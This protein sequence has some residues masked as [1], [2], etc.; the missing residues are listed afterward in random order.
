MH[1]RAGS[2]MILPLTCD[3]FAQPSVHSCLAHIISLAVEAF[4]GAVT[5]TAVAESREAI[6]NYDPALPSNKIGSGIDVIAVI[7]TLAV[8][9]Y[10]S[11]CAMRCMFVCHLRVYLI[12][13]D[14][15]TAQASI[16]TAAVAV[17]HCAPA[18][19]PPSWEHTLGQC[20]QNA[21]SREHTTRGQFVLPSSDGYNANIAL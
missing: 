11:T 18:Y 2:G 15:W 1:T 6:W 20:T 19:Y 12:A 9:V 14:I 13:S 16:Q 21:A 17:W 7:R 4:M 5:Q 10:S 3:E 8:K